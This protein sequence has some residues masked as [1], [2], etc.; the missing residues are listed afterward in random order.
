[1]GN[2]E[3]ISDFAI[4]FLIGTAVGAV[5]G[6]L[7]AP[8]P[9]GE[10]REAVKERLKGITS[11]FERILFNLKW[12]LMSPKERYSYLWSHGGSLHDWS[13]HYNLSEPE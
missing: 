13:P 1:M 10:A 11:P 6:L 9:G 12:M 2:R 8:E 3:L 7:Y 5:V 4:G